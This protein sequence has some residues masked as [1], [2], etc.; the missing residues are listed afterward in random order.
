MAFPITTFQHIVCTMACPSDKVS[1]GMMGV[2]Y[3]VYVK[4]LRQDSIDVMTGQY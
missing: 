4:M 1:H 3:D 2:I